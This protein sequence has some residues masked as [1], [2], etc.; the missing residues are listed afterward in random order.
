MK[1]LNYQKLNIEYVEKL[2]N[3]NE[4]LKKQLINFVSKCLS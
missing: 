4:L 2:E 1:N 3:E